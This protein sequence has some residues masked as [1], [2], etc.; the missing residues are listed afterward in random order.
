M[1]EL[2]KEWLARANDDL[3]T[4]REIIDNSELTNIAAF[5]AQQAIEKSLKA[6]IEEFK[7]G[8]VKIHNL[9]KLFALINNYIQIAINLEMVKT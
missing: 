8:F 2:T 6:V 5:H 3:E 7:I 1:N 9:E 4:I